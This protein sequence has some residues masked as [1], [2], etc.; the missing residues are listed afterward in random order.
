MYPTFFY[1]FNS[2][3]S[4][5]GGKINPATGMFETYIISRGLYVIRENS[6]DFFSDIQHFSDGSNERNAI[7]FLLAQGVISGTGHRRFR[8]NDNI[9]RAEFASMITQL[10]G[11]YDEYS[12]PTTQLF[13]DV[14]PLSDWYFAAVGS[15]H[16]HNIMSGTST[17]P[18]LFKPDEHLT[19]EQFVV[20]IGKILHERMGYNIPQNAD[21]YIEQFDDHIQFSSWSKDYIAIA[22]REGLIA[23]S[24]EFK[25]AGYVTR[26][27]VTLLL[28]NLYLLLW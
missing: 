1:S 18:M 19:R 26:A 3:E 24:G 21:F 28:Y 17:S 23:S 25:P 10:I 12:F 4:P 13:N 8:P 5:V 15:A 20:V 6:G 14:H 16:L 27:E 9:K 7:H 2:A 11:V 22:V